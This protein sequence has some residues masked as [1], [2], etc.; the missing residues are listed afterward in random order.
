MQR[1]DFMGYMNSGAGVSTPSIGV[2]TLVSSSNTNGT[3]VP[4]PEEQYNGVEVLTPSLHDKHGTEVPTPIWN[5][6]EIEVFTLIN[7]VKYKK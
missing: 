6:S 4:A 1:R 7:I 5:K 3:K 2:E